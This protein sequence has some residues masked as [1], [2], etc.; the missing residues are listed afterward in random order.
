MTAHL[1]FPILV[2]L[3]GTN[4]EVRTRKSFVFLLPGRDISTVHKLL[5]RNLDSTFTPKRGKVIIIVVCAEDTII[6]MYV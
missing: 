2:S 1:K 6:Y 5:D 3:F 4:R